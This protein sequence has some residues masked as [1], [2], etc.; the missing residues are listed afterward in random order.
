VWLI[1]TQIAPFS[2][3]IGFVICWYIAFVGFFAGVT[4]MTESRAAVVDKIASAAVHG[5]AGLVAL[6]LGSVIIY[7]FVR[8]FPAFRHLNFFTHT[9]AGVP[10]TAPL[11]QGGIYHAIVGTGIELGIA[12][13]ISLPLGLITAIYLTEVGGRL[14]LV[15]RTII[16]AMTALP[17]LVAGLFI[18]ATLILGLHAIGRTGLAAALALSITMLPI[19]ARSSEVVLRTVP[20]GLREASAA[21]GSPQWR[22]VF[23]VVLPTAKS[24]LATALILGMA[25]GVGETAPVLITSGASAFFN[26]NPTKNPMNSLPFFVYDQLRN[27]GLQPVAISRA[28]GAASVLLALILLLFVFVRFLARDRSGRR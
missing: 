4:A 22:T 19:I 23:S 5:A 14:A 9:M 15:V 20:S 28:Y 3:K 25:R 6:S 21:L 7:T 27:T 26:D 13:V 2:G 18:Y 16:E 17:D 12:V 8:G 24:G 10:S 11:T 1:Y